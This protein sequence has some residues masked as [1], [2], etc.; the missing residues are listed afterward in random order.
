[1]QYILVALN[2]GTRLKHASSQ[3]TVDFF[4]L[5]QAFVAA[6]S[7]VPSLAVAR[8]SP[9]KRNG[10]IDLGMSPIVD[11]LR[12]RGASS[13]LLTSPKT[14]RHDVEPWCS[15]LAA[16]TSCGI[17]HRLCELQRSARLEVERPNLGA[18]ES[19]NFLQ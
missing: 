19:R 16:L 11:R 8:R 14:I 6:L 12:Q 9:R 17:R 13:A 15:A 10:S 4:P 18:I 3:Y 5:D 2:A 1:M 7:R